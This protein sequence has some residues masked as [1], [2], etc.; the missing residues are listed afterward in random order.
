MGEHY[1]N[2]PPGHPA[3]GSAGTPPLLRLHL[4]GGFRVTRDGG[5]PLAERWPRPSAQALVKLLAVA[6]G[7]SLHREQTTEI[8]RP[9]ADPQQALGSLR[10]ALHAA[11][12]ALEP[13]LAPRTASSYLVSDAALL[14][15]DPGTVWI[16]T[17]H[18]ERLAEDALRTP[19]TSGLAAA[20]N[21]F[22]GEL[23][24]EDRYADW[25]QVLRERLA[26]LRDRLR[27]ALA[28]ALLDDHPAEER[29]HQ[30]LMRASLREG[31]RRQAIRQFHACRQALDGELGIR[32]GPVTEHLH[33]QALDTDSPAGPGTVPGGGFLPPAALRG[34]APAPLRGR[35]RALDA[36]LRPAGPPVRLIGGEAGLGKTRLALEAARQ[37][38]V[39]GT[40]V[41]WGAGHDAEGHTPFGAFVEALDGWLAERPPAERAR[42]GT[43]H[44]EL[45]ALL[46]SLGQVGAVAER[47]PEE[48]RERLFRSTAAMLHDL[49]ATA[50]VLI[51]LDD[52]HAADV[53][54]WQLLSHLA[55]RAATAHT[56]WRFLVTY[57]SEELSEFDPRLTV[58]DTLV[59]Q[60]LAEHVGLERLTRADCLALAADTLG[61]PPGHEPPERVWELSLE[62]P[63]FALELASPLRTRNVKRHKAYGSWSPS[64]WHVS[65]PRHAAWWRPSRRRAA[66]RR[67]RT[68]S[69][70]RVAVCIRRCPPRRPRQ[71]PTRPS[72]RR[73]S[74]NATWSPTARAHPGSPSGTR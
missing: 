18:A 19:S 27:L 5:P 11:R 3:E 57:R 41:L 35:G 40:A 70:S 25:A 12:R 4:F 59:R 43:E 68:S 20:L 29:A 45:A 52:L 16:D 39:S 22:T 31:L 72:R 71:V 53:G 48:E 46:P 47:S 54:S 9:D 17:D 37:A 60:Q 32:P 61:L 63:L 73:C 42:T 13:E 64:G 36:L 21:V 38:F 49:A 55:R 51:V 6:P 34:P 69:T 1:T 50:P 23:L 74:P 58:L 62:N 30:L 56:D 65:A 2:Q 7:H 26:G 8:C 67:S 14:R 10:V 28:G 24:P 44:P 33:L 66:T 15:L